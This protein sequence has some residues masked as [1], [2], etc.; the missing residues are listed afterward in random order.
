[1][2]TK[3]F[4]LLALILVLTPPL[5]VAFQV[6]L[7]WETL[8]QMVANH[9]EIQVKYDSVITKA[10]PGEPREFQC[11][12]ELIFS[13]SFSIEKELGINYSQLVEAGYAI[14]HVD[15]INKITS[16]S[17]NVTDDYCNKGS[18]GGGT[19]VQ[20]S[21]NRIWMLIMAAILAMLAAGLLKRR[22]QIVEI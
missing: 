4:K 1:M 8:L 11:K 13:N 10:N 21:F 12:G 9:P 15:Y 7:T 20:Y 17:F 6:P 3:N 16:L 22:L 5:L 19:A 14:A 18:G 2:S